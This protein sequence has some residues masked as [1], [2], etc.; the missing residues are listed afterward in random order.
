[1]AQLTLS[2][3]PP[4]SPGAGVPGRGGEEVVAAGVGLEDGPLSCV[5]SLL[6]VG[7]LRRMRCAHA[8]V[9]HC[10]VLAM[11]CGCPQPPLVPSL[12]RARTPHNLINAGSPH[13]HGTRTLTA[14]SR[15]CISRPLH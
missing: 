10:S 15:R 5:L 13:A 14:V 4:P 2:P 3:G 6:D 1:M 11:Q 8:Q 7:D 9:L 12:Q